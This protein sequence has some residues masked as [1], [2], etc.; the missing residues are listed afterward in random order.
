[1][2]VLDA[3]PASFGFILWA[4]ERVID[5]GEITVMAVL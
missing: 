3:M 4:V 1:M 5:H 2:E